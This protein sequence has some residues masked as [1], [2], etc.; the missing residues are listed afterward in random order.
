M[1]RIKSSILGNV[2]LWMIVLSATN[3]VASVVSIGPFTPSTLIDFTGLSTGTEVNGLTISGDMFTYSL[4]NG[5]VIIDGGPGATNHINPP[6][7]VSVGNDTGTLSLLLSSP[8]TMFE[9]GYAILNTSTVVNAT[10]I[11]VFS[12]ATLLGSLSYT[13]APDPTFTGGF[14]GLESTTAF[15]RVALTFNSAAA[16]AFAVDNIGIAS[17]PEP[18][19]FALVT[20]GLLVCLG[21]AHSSRSKQDLGIKL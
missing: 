4:G 16:P 1:K 17:V 21:V 20:I 13:G 3:A 14:A 11:S 10:T 9:Y 18:A 2:I 5:Q 8:A 15:D 6:N 12:G 7:I 19:T